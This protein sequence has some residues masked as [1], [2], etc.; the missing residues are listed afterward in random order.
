VYKALLKTHDDHVNSTN[1]ITH[2]TDTEK[3]NN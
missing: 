2:Q 1:N 3:P